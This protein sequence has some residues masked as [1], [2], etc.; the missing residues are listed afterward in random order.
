LG[1]PRS[2][3]TLPPPC[4]ASTFVL[5]MSVLPFPVV[6]LRLGKALAYQ[7]YLVFRC[8]DPGL[9]LL[10]KHVE[11]V[12]GVLKVSG[13]DGPIR[14]RAMALDDLH[15]PHAEALQWLGCRISRALLRR[16]ECLTD[17]ATNL[18]RHCAQVPPARSD[19]YHRS[20][21]FAHTNIPINVYYKLSS[22]MS[23]AGI[24]E[25]ILLPLEEGTSAH[26]SCAPALR[27]SG[28]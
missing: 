1:R 19:P 4:F 13:I 21:L 7:F 8:R 22:K 9:R 3:N 11:Y 18:L 14:V 12:H 10:L 24:S 17:V 25:P 15:D 20:S 6:P 27:E 26:E 2:A 16:V 28:G 5:P 23:N